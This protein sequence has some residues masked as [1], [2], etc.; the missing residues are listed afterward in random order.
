M[1]RLYSMA[2]GTLCALAVCDGTRAQ[3]PII[4]DQFSADPSALV[5]NGRI[6]VY[7]S[8]DI[9]APD[10]FARKDWFCM[11]D[12][13]VFSSEDM[14]NWTDHG[15]ILSQ[16]SASWI[17]NKS[18]SMWAPDCKEH[19]GKYYFFYPAQRKAPEGQRFGGFAIG[20]ATAPRP[21]GPFTVEQSPIEGPMGIDPCIFKD[22]DGKG[23]LVWPQRGFVIA[24]LNDDWKSLSG[25]RHTV[26]NTP[27]KGL[28]E[29]PYLFKR[30]GWYYMTFPWAREN[31]EVLAYC[32]SRNIFGPYEFKGVF[33]EEWANGCWT[34]HHSIVEY[35]D[36]WYIFYH[37]NDYSPRFD[38][39]RSVCVDSISFN[40]DGTIRMVHPTL[41]GVGITP[42]VGRIQVD[43]YSSI[44]EGA[45][46]DYLD[47]LNYFAGWKTHLGCKGS[48]VTYNRVD[49]GEEGVSTVQV[50]VR[51]LCGARIDVCAGGRKVQVDV[52]A[53][54]GWQTVSQTVKVSPKGVCDLTIT[55]ASS[56]ETEVDW[57]SFDMSPYTS[58]IFRNSQYFSPVTTQVAKPD[59][60]G[61]IRRWS[62]L[63]PMVKPNRSNV[64][65][66]DSYIRDAF[67]TC[68]PV[69][70]SLNPEDGEKTSINGQELLWHKI[71][72]KLFNVKLFRF[73]SAMKRNVY[74]VLFWAVTEI[75]C[76]DDLTDV[77]LAVG[78]NSA[79]MWW[80]DGK[81]AVIL[82][83]DRRMVRDDC[84]SQR[85]SLSKGKHTIKGAVI[86]GPGMSDFCVRFIDG[87]N[88]PVTNIK[89]HK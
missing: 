5:V 41:R 47:T 44:T 40:A 4:R 18:Y 46:I 50:R 70:F 53:M 31:T 73:A 37:H 87:R 6:Y 68:V 82:S 62:V 34:N 42:A 89:I 60:E 84:T 59:N 66:T 19:D 61:F 21:T 23:Y 2:F 76:E 12:Y 77:R 26:E 38:K 58:D 74:G 56:D 63:E 64:V 16:N 83:G 24:E 29:G 7:P 25:R 28:I 35:K 22:D 20:V 85:L 72:S 51:A 67:M 30:D 86:N 15:V 8:H 79:S 69:P 39:N 11:A 57:V 36:Q 78:S 75:D 43:R 17:D 33:F 49:F 32:M 3:N 27:Q 54:D 80:V 45:S 52:P 65:F 10:D 81:E 55:L 14:I 48:G 71:D 88:N 1:K 9:P 13:H